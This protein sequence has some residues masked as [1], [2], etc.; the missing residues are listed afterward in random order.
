MTDRSCIRGCGVRGEHYA[1]CP[2]YGHETH[3]ACDGCVPREARDGALVCHRCY[4]R[5]YRRLELVPDL[6]EHLRTMV[7]N[8]GRAKEY[9]HVPRAGRGG[10]GNAPASSDMLD[11]SRDL[12]TSIGVTDTTASTTPEET[13]QAAVG[14]VGAIL[15]GFDA[16]ANDAEAF[17]TWWAVVMPVELPE[18]PEF[19][20]VTRALARWPLEDRTRR[21]WHPCAECDL[22]TVLIH[23]PRHPGAPVWYICESCAFQRNDSDDDGLWTEVYEGASR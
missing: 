6:L 4:G 13:R 18:Y 2:A 12:L 15:A 14:H 23:P 22:L 8:V 20:T 19:W 5:L 11:A 1:S 3:E 9:T 16:I 10:N 21:A 17:T 7:H